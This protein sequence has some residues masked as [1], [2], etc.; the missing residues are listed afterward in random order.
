MT[1]QELPG[2]LTETELR[3]QP[4][5]KSA[6]QEDIPADSPARVQGDRREREEDDVHWQNIEQRGTIDEQSCIR[7]CPPRAGVEVEVQK[8][9]QAGPRTAGRDRNG[10]Q[11]DEGHQQ[12]MVEIEPDGA[13]E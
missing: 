10:D 4:D 7:D 6:T 11:K 12:C 8:I 13:S 1:M 3:Q 9:V 2:N 5:S